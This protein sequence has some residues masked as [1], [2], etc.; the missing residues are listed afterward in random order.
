MLIHSSVSDFSLV[1]DCEIEHQL[2]EVGTGWELSLGRLLSR[3]A[4]PVG[5]GAD[6]DENEN[7]PDRHTQDEEQSIFFGPVAHGT[8]FRLL[9][10]PH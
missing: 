5:Q 6:Q 3:A 2:T 8:R 7:C 10:A 1:C 9:F 4:L